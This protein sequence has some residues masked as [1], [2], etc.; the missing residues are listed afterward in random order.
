MN[1]YRQIL[2]HIVFCT[3]ERKNIIPAAHQEEHHKKVN[4][5]D[6]YRELLKEHDIIADER[7]IF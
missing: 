2:Y 4:F 1:S 3:H 7:Y 6:E 5:E